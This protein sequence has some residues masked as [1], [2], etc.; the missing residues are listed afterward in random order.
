[1]APRNSIL[2]CIFFIYVSAVFSFSDYCLT[3]SYRRDVGIKEATGHNDGP[4]VEMWLKHAGVSK[5]N[6][7]CSAFVKYHLDECDIPNKIT[8]FSPSAFNKNNVV[9]HKG[10]WKKEP[11]PGD[12]FVIYFQKL[13]RIGHTGFYDGLKNA[14]FIKTVEAN[15]N[16]QNS[17][18]G[19]GVYIRY[20]SLNTIYGISRWTE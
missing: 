1:M 11:K 7:Y 9:Y 12:V 8:A 19:N 3:E 16:S 5:G 2:F 14:K 10:N 13:K 15:T 18:E 6:P 20:R 4:E 17:R